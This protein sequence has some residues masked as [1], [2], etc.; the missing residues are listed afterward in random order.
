M[1]MR[2]GEKRTSLLSISLIYTR[3][4]NDD[5]ETLKEEVYFETTLEDAKTPLSSPK[6]LYFFVF[7]FC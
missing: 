4:N 2:C 7:F 6:F 5:E 1:K 3:E